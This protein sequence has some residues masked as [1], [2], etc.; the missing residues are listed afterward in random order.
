MT[1]IDR[2]MAYCSQSSPVVPD[3]EAR[4]RKLNSDLVAIRIE[5]MLINHSILQKEDEELK[6]VFAGQYSWQCT[7]SQTALDCATFLELL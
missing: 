3:Q 5:F 7:E 4:R 6:I 2:W 1:G